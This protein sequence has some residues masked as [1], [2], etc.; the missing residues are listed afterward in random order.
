MMT[1]STVFRAMNTDIVLLSPEG[2]R[3]YERAGDAVRCVFTEVERCLSRFRPD[4]ELSV[5]NRS[6]G[7]SFHASP[8][9]FRAVSLA[10]KAAE[11]TNGLFDPTILS[12]LEAAGYDRS[13]ELIGAVAQIS[14]TATSGKG[15]SADYRSIRCDASSSTIQLGVGQRIDLGGIGKGLAVDL[16]LAATEELPSRCI[17]AGGDLAVRGA[18]EGA[19]GWT[20]ALEDGGHAAPL[21]VQVTDAALATS[22]TLKR[23]WMAGDEVCHHLIDPRTGRPSTSSLRTVTVV[24]ATC[25]QADIAAKTALLLGE[26]GIAFLAERGMHGF[27]VRTDSSAT[28]TS[29]WPTA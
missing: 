4:S 5:L 19:T 8:L 11:E 21:S 16:A 17:N 18:S 13:F 3:A 10:V 1:V 20:I 25:V 9:L 15:S 26:D 27:A 2:G 29:G 28:A 22:T 7:R 23:R 12:T 6:E 24:A 14:I